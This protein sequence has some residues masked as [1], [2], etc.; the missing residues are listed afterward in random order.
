MDASS[1]SLLDAYDAA[2]NGRRHVVGTMSDARE[3]AAA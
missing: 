2:N 3:D 1:R